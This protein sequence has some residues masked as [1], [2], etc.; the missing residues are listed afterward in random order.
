MFSDENTDQDLLLDGTVNGLKTLCE[1]DMGAQKCIIPERMAN[2]LEVT[3]TA[4]CQPVGNRVVVN[5][6]KVHIKVG[7][8]DALVTAAVA[9]N[10]LLKHP[11]IGRNVGVKLLLDCCRQA[12]HG[13]KDIETLEAHAVKTRAQTKKEEREDLT[14][15]AVRQ[16]EQAQIVDPSE[17]TQTAV[18]E[19]LQ[20]AA[21]VVSTM[22]I[23]EEDTQAKVCESVDLNCNLGLIIPAMEL[24]DSLGVEYR[25]ELAGDE[26]L[27]EWKTHADVRRYGFLWDDGILKRVVEDELEGNRELVVIPVGLRS[28]ML[29]LV[30][31]HLGHVGAGKMAWML[32][33]SCTWPGISGDVKRY[34]KAC[35]ECQKMRKGG[36]SEVP[37]GVMPIYK[38]PFENVA[39][40]IVGPFPRSHGYKYLLTYICLASKYPE[41]IPLRFATAQ[42][43][44]KA[45]LEIFARN[46]V[47]MLLLS[48]QG[49]Q[50][51]GALMRNL[52]ERL[53]VHQIRT[54]PYHPQSNGSVEQLHGTLVPM[55]RKLV[56]KD[57]P[58]DLQVKFALF[59]IR[60][61]PNRSTGYAPFQIV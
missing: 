12:V 36:A 20:E 26:T 2:G 45:L 14:V 55:L 52:C 43:C 11:L 3:G 19:D 15:E 13:D 48:D 54:T 60:A 18:A 42:E 24:G 29:I 53:G 7:C 37:M 59:A 51:M 56:Q 39:I 23:P 58:W 40:D 6:V 41:A 5:T 10:G 32:R 34:G 38:V 35:G 49:S 17:V 25:A 1:L 9:K 30:H 44:A 28:S 8:I 27:V 33:Q 16:A 61:T 22:V 46:G 50:F 4:I 21:G 57:L 31:D 47:P